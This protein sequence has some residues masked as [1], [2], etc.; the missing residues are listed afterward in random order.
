MSVEK[1]SLTSLRCLLFFY[2]GGAGCLLPFLSLHAE[3]TGLGLKNARLIS[4]IAP[5]F[6]TLGP[7]TVGPLVDYLCGKKRTDKSPKNERSTQI[8]T[9]LSLTILLSAVFYCLL[10]SVPTVQRLTPRQPS[11]SFVCNEYGASLVQEKCNELG[12]YRFPDQKTGLIRLKACRFDCDFPSHYGYIENPGVEP[13]TEPTSTDRIP[14]SRIK[15]EPEFDP[16]DFFGTEKYK[17]DD[18]SDFGSGEEEEEE[19]DFN[20]NRRNR[21]RDIREDNG[22][23]LEEPPHICYNNLLQSQ[24]VEDR[25]LRMCFVYTASGGVFKVNV[26]LKPAHEDDQHCS[27]PL[28]GDF[29]CRIPENMEKPEESCKVVCDIEDAYVPG[30]VLVQS[31]CRDVNG[32]VELAFWLYLTFR[33]LGDLFF[34]VSVSLAIG[35]TLVAARERIGREFVLPSVAYCAFSLLISY[36]HSNSLSPL[37]LGNIPHFFLGIVGFGLLSMFALFV[38][39]FASDLPI[40]PP[41]WWWNTRASN[42]Y[43]KKEFMAVLVVLALLGML[44]GPLYFHVP[45]HITERKDVELYVGAAAAVAAFLSLPFVWKANTIV[46]YCGFSNVF[47]AAFT[48]YILRYTG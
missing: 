29:S 23:A 26:T 22:L 34:V 21:K 20:W 15:S 37:K 31:Q 1:A 13:K 46:N 17:E 47:I 28:G 6:A 5:L 9:L 8:R 4:F 36:L 45:W 48:F 11:V 12:C 19:V 39:I 43:H 14:S 3:A 38:L 42:V 27:F 33:S 25:N 41:D 18:Y 16:D 40:G 2:F 10:L 7:V 24:K 35:S 44:W 32:D 30:S